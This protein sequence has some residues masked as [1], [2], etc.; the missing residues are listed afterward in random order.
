MLPQ[1]MMPM[2][3]RAIAWSDSH[4]ADKSVAGTCGLRR[5][6]GLIMLHHHPPRAR[7]PG[8]G[9]QV[10]P[11]QNAGADIRPS[12]LVLVSP[13]RRDILYMRGDDA[14]PVA[15]HPLFGIGAAP[16]QPC[17]V[18]LPRERAALRRL[19]DQLQRGLRAVLRCEFPVV[20]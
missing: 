8:G 15:P 10:P 16:Y 9:P 2:L 19:E 7:R 5:I 18:H 11:V 1:P 4:A 17:D 20:V 13:M 6:G 14:V 3:M 12:I